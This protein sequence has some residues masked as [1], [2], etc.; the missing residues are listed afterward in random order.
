MCPCSYSPV[1]RKRR[2]LI[3]QPENVKI[4]GTREIGAKVTR[5]LLSVV[6]PYAFVVPLFDPYGAACV[7]VSFISKRKHYGFYQKFKLCY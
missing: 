3:A 1:G 6:K 5:A 4:S 2:D 7:G